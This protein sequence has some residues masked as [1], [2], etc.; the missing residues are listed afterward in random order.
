MSGGKKRAREDAPHDEERP[1]QRARSH[2][3]DDV[4]ENTGGAEEDEDGHLYGAAPQLPE[5]FLDAED[6]YDALRVQFKAGP[7]VEFYG[8][9][10]LAR[11]GD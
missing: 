7:D 8:T 11:Y 10:W 9:R 4:P 6:L 3:S 2:A 5:D 1:H